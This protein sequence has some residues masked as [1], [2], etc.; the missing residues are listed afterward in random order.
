MTSTPAPAPAATALPARTSRTRPGPA[1]AH[2]AP[3]D[4]QPG[5]GAAI[6]RQDGHYTRADLDPGPASAAARRITRNALTRWNLPGSLTDDAELIASELAANAS[7]ATPPGSP[8]PAIILT[9]HHQPP[10]LTIRMWDAGPG[11]PDP[12]DPGHDAEEGRGLLLIHHLSR[13]WGWWPCP[14]SGGKVV[15]STLTTDT[16]QP[17]ED[18]PV[19]PADDQQLAR[20]Q[21]SHA[22]RW[23]IWLIRCATR[24][25]WC[26]K[27]AGT[28]T[29]IHHEAAPEHLDRWIRRVDGLTGSGLA[30]TFDGTTA[31]VTWTPPGTRTPAVYGPAPIPDALAHAEDIRAR[32]LGMIK[33]LTDD[34]E[35]TARHMA[36][37]QIR[38]L[39][40]HVHDPSAR[41]VL[42][43]ITS[44]RAATRAHASGT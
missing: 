7:A 26:C 30:I 40:P 10:D 39:I 1:P 20:L 38:D 18:N 16:A 11:E 29:G 35:G 12:A 42:Q 27:P 3:A 28:G 44:H 2:P 36:D 32:R 33:W 31:T 19:K 6:A 23:D 14:H 17:A 21:A 25:W 22:A 9:L 24:S 13:D 5:T 41:R 15:F 4:P 37:A 34:P 43:A 8:A